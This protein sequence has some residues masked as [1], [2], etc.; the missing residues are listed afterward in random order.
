MEILM[1]LSTV[2]TNG[3]LTGFIVNNLLLLW[4][5]TKLTPTKKDD[6][7]IEALKERM[8]LNGKKSKD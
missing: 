4:V 3:W 6:G 2:G 1:W 7:F 8:G 5:I